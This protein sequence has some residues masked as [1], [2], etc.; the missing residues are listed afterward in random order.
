MGDEVLNILAEEEVVAKAEKDQNVLLQL[1]EN[2]RQNPVEP[3]NNI[4]KKLDTIQTSF[5][6]PDK[7]ALLLI[8]LYREREMEFKGSVKRHTDLWNEIAQV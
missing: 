8:E 6:W 3:G 7:A 5:V 1:I 2:A 4:G